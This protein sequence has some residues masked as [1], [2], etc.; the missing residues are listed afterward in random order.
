[1]KINAN[2]NQN[3]KT[4]TI[5][6]NEK[7][8]NNKT[9]ITNKYGS[10]NNINTVNKKIKTSKNSIKKTIINKPPMNYRVDTNKL[11]VY[12]VYRT[13]KM[14][15]ITFTNILFINIILFLNI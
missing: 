11:Y 5:S 1:M 4:N 15:I 12:N 14:F 8:N 7:L 3:K 2:E 13:L 10:K 6:S 9:N